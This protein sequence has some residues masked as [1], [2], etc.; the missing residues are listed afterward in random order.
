LQAFV[1]ET[2]ANHMKS[3]GPDDLAYRTLSVQIHVLDVVDSLHAW[4]SI[5]RYVYTGEES[6]GRWVE[7]LEDAFM[8]QEQ[9]PTELRN[10]LD[11]SST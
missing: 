10:A 1:D 4:S 3:E 11:S 8:L 9:A 2:I 7:R 5:P 6:F